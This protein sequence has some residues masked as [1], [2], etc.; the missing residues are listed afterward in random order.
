MEAQSI[1]QILQRMLPG[2]SAA[3]PSSLSPL[4]ARYPALSRL[5]PAALDRLTCRFCHGA[6]QTPLLAAGCPTCRGTGLVCPTCRARTVG[7]AR[8]RRA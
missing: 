1:G 2:G 4:L 5:P 8:R 7:A 3:P 6:G